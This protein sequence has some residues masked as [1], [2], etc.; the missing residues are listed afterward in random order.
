M[1][2]LYTKQQDA[3]DIYTTAQ[4]NLDTAKELW[5]SNKK[6]SYTA[7]RTISCFCGRDYTRPMSY[8]IINN[9]ID[10]TTLIYADSGSQVTME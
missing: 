4:K 9:T 2:D 7:T 3:K 6:E 5:K 10:T 1:K 8:Q